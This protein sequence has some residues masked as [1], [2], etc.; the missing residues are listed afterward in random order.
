MD[1]KLRIALVTNNYTP[2]SGGVV[3]S[4]NASVAQLQQQGHT[5]RIFTFNF[6]GEQHMHD[7]DYVVR[8]ACP[9][10][11]KYKQNHMAI[12][13]RA[14]KQLRAMFEEFQPDIVHSHHPFLLGQTA[15]GVANMLRVPIVFTFHTL[16]EEYVHYVPL[17]SSITRPAVNKIVR[18]YCNQ[19][20][21]IIAPTTIM[22]D[23]ICGLGV[24]VPITVLPSAVQECYV[25]QM[26]LPVVTRCESD[27]FNLLLV[28]R[29]TPEKN[30]PFL[31]DVFTQLK[32]QH[33]YTFTLVGYGSEYEFLQEYAY[34]KL[35]LSSEQIIFVRKPEREQL[36]Q[37]YCQADLFLF[38]SL[39]DT[40]GLVLAEAMASSTPVIALDGPGQRAIIINGANGFLVANQQ[41][42]ATKIEEVANDS[43]L[44]ARMREGA[45]KT[46]LEYAPEVIG[47]RLLDCY[48]QMLKDQMSIVID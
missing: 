2:F 37:F 28:S 27:P 5:V 33:A 43:V 20:D 4:I 22:Q 16:Y 18:D 46:A 48:W 7:P 30:I 44:H 3:S 14:H 34:Q 1:K 13:W 23:Y 38:S 10:R 45:R 26:A 24:T 29:F 36:L 42:M 11:F 17:H 6:L 25:Q 39:S 8:L 21:R 31:L 32:D 9:I 19:V 47:V 15:V 41:E 35:G 40:Q 12:A